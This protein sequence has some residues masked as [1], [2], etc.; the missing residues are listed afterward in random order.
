MFLP[1]LPSGAHRPEADLSNPLRSFDSLLHP[2]KVPPAPVIASQPHDFNLPD[3]T[4]TVCP[5]SS[6]GPESGHSAAVRR[7]LTST[8]R[9]PARHRPAVVSRRRLT[10]R[11][12]ALHRSCTDQGRSTRTVH[13]EWTTATFGMT[14]SPPCRGHGRIPSHD[15]SSRNQSSACPTGAVTVTGWCQLRVASSFL[16]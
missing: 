1:F 16:L 2:E 8:L 5:D 11:G 10:I 4:G 7:F 13:A 14:F 9:C 15:A 3:L 6:A 12:R